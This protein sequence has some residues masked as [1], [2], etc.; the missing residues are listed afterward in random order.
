MSDT[1]L[2]VL[3]SFPQRLGAGRVCYTAWQQVLGLHDAGA[4]V[5]VLTGSVARPL[6]PSVEVRTTLSRGKVRLPYRLLG[7]TRACELHDRLVARQLPRLAEQ[8]DVVHVWPRGARHTLAA[9]RALGIPTFLERPNAHTRFA[10]ETVA[11]E[12]ER[13]GIVLPKGS[14]H[15]YDAD[16]LRIEEAEFALADWLLCPSDFV[17]QTFLDQGTLPAKLVRHTYGVDLDRF[18]P[19]PRERT[20]RPFTALFAGYAAVRKGLHL[21]LDAWLDS[22]LAEEGVLLVAGGIMPEYAAVLRDG[23]AHPSVHVL[24]HRDDLPAL[25][26]DAD[27]TLLPSLEEGFGL[28]CIEAMASGSVPVVSDACTELCR[29]EENA[30]VHRAGDVPQLRDHLTRM[31]RDRP[32]LERLRGNALRT[33]QDVTWAAA[34]R[35]LL[36]VYTEPSAARRV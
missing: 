15:A 9:A 22:P 29:H 19:R 3:Y 35:R 23:L 6:P 31:A 8:V 7:M 32:M 12:S 13:L 16:V 20:G 11:E 21:A 2:R 17:A 5:T 28:V 26:A 14:E 1:A 10:Y 25:M 34:G 30:L 33:A 4:Q 24:G 27:V 18:G 36:E